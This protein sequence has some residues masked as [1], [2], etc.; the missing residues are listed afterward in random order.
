M[1]KPRYFTWYKDLLSRPI[2]GYCGIMGMRFTSL[3]APDLQRIYG[4]VYCKR[5]Y[6]DPGAEGRYTRRTNI[7]PI[8][9]ASW[10]R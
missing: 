5:F 6:V 7:N 4:E 9:E 1:K 8:R 10:P 3:F 2:K